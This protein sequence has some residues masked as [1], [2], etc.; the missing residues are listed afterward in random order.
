MAAAPKRSHRAV[1]CSSMKKASRRTPPRRRTPWIKT[2]PSAPAL[3]AAEPCASSSALFPHLNDA[4]LPRRH[5]DA[6]RHEIG[7][8][9]SRN[10]SA[11][12][13]TLVAVA[14]AGDEATR[15][16]IRQGR[17]D[18]RRQPFPRRSTPL[19]APRKRL[20]AVHRHAERRHS[21]ERENTIPITPRK[22]R[23]AFVQ[24]GFNE[25]RSRAPPKKRA[26]DLTEASRLN[27]AALAAREARSRNWPPV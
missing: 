7:F 16:R 22:S 20:R 17:Q 6:T 2:P 1:L 3:I 4:M 15:P 10:D 19:I 27:E 5:F 14:F 12:P 26:A 9:D 21:P 25:V 18:Q 8:D 11:S 13:K 23:R 24:S